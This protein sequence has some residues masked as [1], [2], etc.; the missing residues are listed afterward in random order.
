MQKNANKKTAPRQQQKVT[1]VKLVDAATTSAKKPPPPRENKQAPHGSSYL[2]PDAL[3][4]AAQTEDDILQG[5]VLSPFQRTMAIT[6]YGNA[7]EI[8]LF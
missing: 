5:F 1:K 4:S 3:A 7:H 6:W 2:K 8:V